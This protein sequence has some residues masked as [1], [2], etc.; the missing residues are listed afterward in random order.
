MLIWAS[1]TAVP[2]RHIPRPQHPATPSA[3]TST[4]PITHRSRLPGRKPAPS[5]RT[6]RTGSAQIG[7]LSVNGPIALYP[8]LGHVLAMG[9]LAGWGSAVWSG[10]SSLPP[11]RRVQLDVRRPLGFPPPDLRRRQLAQAALDH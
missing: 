6:L 2:R 9:P 1:L 5:L 10:A 7:Q 4:P 3:A 11:G 8:Q